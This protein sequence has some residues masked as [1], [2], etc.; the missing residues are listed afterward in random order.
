MCF[1]RAM[2]KAAPGKKM[3]V[4]M[5]VL[6]SEHTQDNLKVNFLSYFFYAYLGNSIFEILVKKN[7][8]YR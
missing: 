8:I 6:K 7:T 4:A 5:K 1:Y 3:E 2:W